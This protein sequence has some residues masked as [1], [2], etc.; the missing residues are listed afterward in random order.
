MSPTTRRAVALAVAA[1]TTATSASA[2]IQPGAAPRRGEEIRP[3]R[4]LLRMGAAALAVSYLPSFV[5]ASTS[6]R[7]GDQWLFV[8]I[9]GPWVDLGTREGCAISGGD[10]SNEPLFRVALIAAGIV[11]VAGA[12]ALIASFIL[13]EYRVERERVGRARSAQLTVAPL[14]LTKDSFGLGLTGRF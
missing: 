9:V 6:H 3:S 13:P 10:C 2:E 7:D 14:R 5:V 12:T 11:Q 8:P 1:V 4:S